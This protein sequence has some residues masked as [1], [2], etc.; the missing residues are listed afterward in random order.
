MRGGKALTAAH[1]ETLLQQ[2]HPWREWGEPCAAGLSR[3]CLLHQFYDVRWTRDGAKR[4][5]RSCC[6]WAV[7]LQVGYLVC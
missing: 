2:M 4:C 5:Q 1:G 7:L 3:L 6:S